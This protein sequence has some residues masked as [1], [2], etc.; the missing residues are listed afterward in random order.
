MGFKEWW[1]ERVELVVWD[2]GLKI[3]SWMEKHCETLHV[4]LHFGHVMQKIDNM[5]IQIC[6]M[7]VM[8]WYSRPFLNPSP[9][10]E[11]QAQFVWQNLAE[12]RYSLFL[13]VGFSSYTEAFM[14]VLSQI[15]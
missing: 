6:K 5:V 2:V 4:L 15:L 3:T 11:I 7:W 9:L 1:N 8:V 14:S 10:Q 12:I 13:Q